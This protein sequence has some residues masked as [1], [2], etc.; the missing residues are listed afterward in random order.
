MFQVLDLNTE[1]LK[2]FEDFDLN[3]EGLEVFEVLDSQ[4]N[5]IDF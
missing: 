4:H 1:D 5:V 2:L 3:T